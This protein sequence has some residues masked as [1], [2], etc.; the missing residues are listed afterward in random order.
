[1]VMNVK[2]G[3]ADASVYV[4]EN[5]IEKMYIGETVVLGQEDIYDVY[6]VDITG[7]YE[8]LI[9][10]CGAPNFG[11]KTNSESFTSPILGGKLYR[12]TGTTD[13]NVNVI[14]QIG[15]DTDWIGGKFGSSNTTG[16]GLKKNGKVYYIAQTDSTND[17]AYHVAEVPSVSSVTFK[18]LYGVTYSTTTNGQCMMLSDAGDIYIG[19]YSITTTA[20]TVTK[21]AYISGVSDLYGYY[22]SGYYHNAVLKEG[23]LYTCKGSSVKTLT[24]QDSLTFNSASSDYSG[25]S[26]YYT[27][28]I[29]VDASGNKRIAMCSS[30]GALTTVTTS[31]V[32]RQVCGR[33][34]ATYKYKAYAVSEDG[35]MYYATA[36]NTFAKVPNIEGVTRLNGA[37]GS[38]TQTAL[39]IADDSLFLFKY[40]T[41]TSVVDITKVD[42]S[43]LGVVVGVY[44]HCY[45]NT[46]TGSM[47]KGIFVVKRNISSV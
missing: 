44:G 18:K 42:T 30:S 15:L 25:V 37:H 41:D 34:H 23:K 40:N 12:Y 20:P 24:G 4:G 19:G 26:G 17:A 16:Y 45:E 38:Y 9:E 35:Y 36:Y 32:P 14:V 21:Y 2:L 31:F 22:R 46:S 3:E 47:T 33:F 39:G 28:H 27:P 29:A 1:M 43:S 7:N 6:S 5:K 13:S 10:N 8:L 11:Y